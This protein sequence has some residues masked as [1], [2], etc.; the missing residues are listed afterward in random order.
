MQ[1]AIPFPV[2]DPVAISIGPL[3]IRWYALAYIAGI[4]LGWLYARWLASRASLWGERPRPNAR[5]LDDLIT[6]ATLGIVIGGRLG[7]VLVYNPQYYLQHPLEALMIWQGGMAFHGGLLGVVVAVIIFARVKKLPALTFFDVL[8]VVVPLGL[9]FGRIANFINGE[10]YG[11]PS[12]VSWAMVFPGAGPEA[13]HPSQ[14]YQAAL[15]GLFLFLLLAIAVRLGAL[16]RPGLA[17]GLFAAG[18]GVARVVG[19]AFR[20]PDPQLGF[21]YGPVTM[22]ML[23][24]LPMLAIGLILIVR[25]AMRPP[26]TATP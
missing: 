23:L 15:E 25:A 4:V 17:M 21:L 19:E 5:D 16:R 14:L 26:A 24:S 6:W 3:A 2:F 22:G 12:D 11:R 10:L 7:F 8:G 9:F 20:M 1:L 18:Y 13:R